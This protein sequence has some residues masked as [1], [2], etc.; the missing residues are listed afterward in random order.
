MKAVLPALT[1]K[2][3]EG[4]AIADGGAASRAYL[5]VTFR[6]ATSVERE[7]VRKQLEDYCALDTMGMVQ[8]VNALRR[9]SN[10]H[11]EA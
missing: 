5:R 1:G 10:G 3:Y 2:S 6:E 9:L 11:L 7:K 8:I 4:M